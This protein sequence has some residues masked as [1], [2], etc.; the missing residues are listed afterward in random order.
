[1]CPGIAR[2]GRGKVIAGA[3]ANVI[4]GFELSEVG[5]DVV[6]AVFCEMSHCDYEVW[7]RTES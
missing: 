6:N 3:I 2:N 5:L 1:M 4:E 7:K